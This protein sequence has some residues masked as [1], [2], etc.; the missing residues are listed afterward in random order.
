M[1]KKMMDFD[2]Y[3]ECLTSIS[4]K[5]LLWLCYSHYSWCLYHYLKINWVFKG[6]KK[7]KTYWSTG[8]GQ[9][10]DSDIPTT[11]EM[12]YHKWEGLLFTLGSFTQFYP[13]KIGRGMNF[14]HLSKFVSSHLKR[15]LWREKLT[16]LQ[17]LIN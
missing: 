2:Y 4:N 10:T 3:E 5:I 13:G 17:L 12:S 1:K 6:L 7:S 9:E 8:A 14:L 16:L 11:L 15:F